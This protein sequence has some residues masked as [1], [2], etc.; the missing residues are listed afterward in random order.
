MKQISHNIDDESIEAKVLWFRT[1]PIPDRME[2]LCYFTDLA[3]EFN[4]DLAGKKDAQS[5]KG[6]V[7]ILSKT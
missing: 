4:P 6:S 7:R 1:L 3:L 5:T 2:L